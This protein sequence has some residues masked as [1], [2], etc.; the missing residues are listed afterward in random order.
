VLLYVCY[1]VGNR[2]AYVYG[3]FFDFLTWAAWSQSWRPGSKL[4]KALMMAIPH[5]LIRNSL[6][7]ACKPAIKSLTIRQGL[8]DARAEGKGALV[9]A[10]DSIQTISGFIWPLFYARVSKPLTNTTACSSALI[11]PRFSTKANGR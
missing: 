8:S 1:A 2:R 3:S 7:Q 10:F 9:A 4:G 6:A 5:M 11:L